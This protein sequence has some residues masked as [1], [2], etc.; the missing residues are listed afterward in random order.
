[1]SNTG[2]DPTA[3]L[4]S[5]GTQASQMVFRIVDDLGNVVGESILKP[6]SVGSAASL[7]LKL[8]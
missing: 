8:Q 5:T 2:F 6:L 7:D 4:T 3:S 1:V